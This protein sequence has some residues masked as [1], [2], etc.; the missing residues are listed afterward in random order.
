MSKSQT[1]TLP[2]LVSE[3]LL[4]LSTIRRLSKH[5]VSAYRSDLSTFLS[6]CQDNKL[7]H[8][9]AVKEPHLRKFSAGLNAKGLSAKS[10]QRKM[11]SIRGLYRFHAEHIASVDRERMNPALHV[12][13][14]KASRKLPSLVDIEQLNQLLDNFERRAM[15]SESGKAQQAMHARNYAI[16]ELF[17]GSGMRLSELVGLNISDFDF[18]ANSV[19][20]LGKGRKT[21][22]IPLGSKSIFACKKWSSMRYDITNSPDIIEENTASPFFVSKK[23]TRLSGRTVQSIV[24]QAAQELPNQQK[25]HP[26]KLRHSYASH[27][28]ESSQDLRAVQELLGHS[29]ISTTQIYTHLDFQQ[30][31]N[32]YDD[33][34]PRAQKKR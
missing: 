5:T 27:L 17:Y 10:L 14:P 13:A 30:L 8:P 19:S 33:F 22:S 24:A 23:G 9:E 3:Y 11:S 6:F 2:I 4:H 21:R 7:V 12:K 28:L 1:I 20:V 32:A 29:N 18:S 25:L 31:S 15:S 26:H 34:H 16:L